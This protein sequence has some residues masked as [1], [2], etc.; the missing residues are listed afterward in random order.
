MA[1]RY[2]CKALRAVVLA[3]CLTTFASAQAEAANKKTAEVRWVSITVREGD[4]QKKYQHDLKTI[5]KKESAKANWGKPLPAPIEVSVEI[6]EM[7]SVVG[8]DVVQVTCT[9]VGRIKGGKAAR[10]RF[11]YGG[12]PAE[13]SK[14]EQRVLKLVAQGIVTRLSSMARNIPRPKVKK[15]SKKKTTAKAPK[16]KTHRKKR[17]GLRAPE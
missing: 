6:R 8:K 12:A 3:L 11:S 9:A 7:R 14:V 5:L 15:V 10:T 13:Q 17:G 4:H 2:L 16:K 1:D